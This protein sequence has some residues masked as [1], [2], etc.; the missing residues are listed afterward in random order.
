MKNYN[1]NCL[2]II[3]V[4]IS[5]FTVAQPSIQESPTV[6][7]LSNRTVNLMDNPN[8][9]TGSPYYKEDFLRGSIS[10]DGKVIAF[11]Q[12]L[13]YNVSKEEFEIKDPT[14]KNSK[15][16]STVLRSEDF[17]IKIGNDSFEY[18]SSEKNALRGY[19]IVLFKGKKN[20]L[21]KKV[22]KKYYP[23]QKAPNSMSNDIDA[24][25]RDKETLY[26]VNEAGIFTELSSSKNS[27][28]KAFGS[29][30]KKVKTY[31]KENDLNPNDEADLIQVVSHFDAL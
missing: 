26:L 22:T 3:A 18:I 6:Q 7:Y 8:D 30:K 9:Y 21:Y 2:S 17:S 25:Y 13:R 5:T 19:F 29:L 16:V 15:I 1:I 24:M 11:N 4:L 12:D 20:A 23:A 31:V 14:N 27:K 10:V 28:I